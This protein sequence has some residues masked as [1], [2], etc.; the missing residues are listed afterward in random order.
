[1]KKKDKRVLA[2]LFVGLGIMLTV[3]WVVGFWVNDSRP[4]WALIARALTIPV[5]VIGAVL[6]AERIS[7]C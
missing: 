1:M 7:E 5:M 2:E 6:S 4:E 3:A